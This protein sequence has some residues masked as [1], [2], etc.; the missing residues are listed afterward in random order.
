MMASLPVRAANIMKL[1]KLILRELQP[2]VPVDGELTEDYVESIVYGS[3]HDVIQT[4]AP[5]LE[6]HAE[7]REIGEP[8]FDAE[9]FLDRLKKAHDSFLPLPA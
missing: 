5:L 2:G 1:A 7:D 6:R 4:L 9:G 3:P 8:E